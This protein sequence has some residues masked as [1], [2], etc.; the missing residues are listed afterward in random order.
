MTFF[1][2]NFLDIGLD[3]LGRQ[4]GAERFRS[5]IHLHL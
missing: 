3:D 5:A 1:L 4:Q 2:E